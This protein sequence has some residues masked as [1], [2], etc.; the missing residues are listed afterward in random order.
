[1]NGKRH[2]KGTL[3]FALAHTQAC[4]KDSE[5][6]TIFT[7]RGFLFSFFFDFSGLKRETNKGNRFFFFVA[8][9]AQSISGTSTTF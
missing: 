6:F 1:M 7:Y 8:V 9:A 2:F 3:S 5:L 4:Y